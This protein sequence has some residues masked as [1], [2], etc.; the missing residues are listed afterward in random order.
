[1]PSA[2]SRAANAASAAR[3][4]ESPP[5]V[6]PHARRWVGLGQRLLA[7]AVFV[8][9]FV[10]I[11]WR[12]DV[13]FVLLV[14]FILVTG[15]REFQ[16]MLAAKGLQTSSVTGVAAAV[17]LPWLAFWDGG[18]HEDVGLA[19]LLGLAMFGSINFTNAIVDL[20]K[21]V[22]PV[23]PFTFAFRV[24]HYG[25]YGSGA[26][27]NRLTPLFIGYSDLVRGYDAGSFTNEELAADSSHN[28]FNRLF[29]S[30]IAVANFELRFPLFGALHLGGGYYG[31][32]PLETGV[33]YDAGAAWSPDGRF[34]TFT[35]N[36]DGRESIYVMRADGSGAAS[37]IFKH[38]PRTDVLGGVA[39]SPDGNEV[40]FAAIKFGLAH[41]L[42]QK[43]PARFATLAESPHCGGWGACR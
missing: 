6:R 33:F 23:R 29:G 36:R 7:A 34:I 15:M 2:S 12:G 11:S 28:V 10:I 32:L 5:A 27:D 41:A 13:Y 16:R 3:P 1:M 25:R 18:A 8:P 14:D 38:G 31:I 17:I 9:A 21:Y 4:E 19:A 24:L 42:P 39:W 30:K 22:M 20:R 40:W 37:R 35:S 26:E 43:V